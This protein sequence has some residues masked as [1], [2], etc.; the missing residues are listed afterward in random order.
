MTDMINLIGRLDRLLSEM[1]LAAEETWD[2]VDRRTLKHH[3]EDMIGCG[4]TILK[5]LEKKPT[6][7]YLAPKPGICSFCGFLAN[8]LEC[9]LQHS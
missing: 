9:Q 8:S 5:K 7:A 4:E 1:L 2:D 3:A 6:T